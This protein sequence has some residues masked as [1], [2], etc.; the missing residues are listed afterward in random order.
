MRID[1]QCHCGA[2]RY[3]AEIDPELVG[4]CHCTDCQVLTGSPYRVSVATSR[5]ALQ[6]SGAPKC[7]VKV[8][9]SGRKRYQ[10]FCGDCGAPI[11]V[12]GEPEDEAIALRWGAIRQ[13]LEL[14]PK[15]QIWCD[16]A[17][18]WAGPTLSLPKLARD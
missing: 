12:T 4:I 7:Y 17:L 2:V 14:T 11:Y 18:S 15:R 8:G 16:S 1:G 6:L 10:Y 3:Q 13:R 9:D 5:S